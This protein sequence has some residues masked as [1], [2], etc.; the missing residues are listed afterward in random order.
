MFSTHSHNAQLQS[1]DCRT[2]R[3]IRER[4]KEVGERRKRLV[5]MNTC[6]QMYCLLALK[7][8]EGDC[9][10]PNGRGVEFAQNGLRQYEIEGEKGGRKETEREVG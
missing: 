6:Y 2:E 3:K 7:Q 4:K 1:E 10:P 5:H 8:E 9:F